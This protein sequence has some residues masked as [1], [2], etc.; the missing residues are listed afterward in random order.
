M[1]QNG[2]IYTV[3]VS[4]TVPSALSREKVFFD[5]SPT[6]AIFTANNNANLLHFHFVLNCVISL[7]LSNP[8]S[9]Q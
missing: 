6:Q 9:S 5:T 1:V 3:L 2:G 4:F 7:L 8:E